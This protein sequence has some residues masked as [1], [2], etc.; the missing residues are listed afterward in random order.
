MVF[1]TLCSLLLR[2][3]IFGHKVGVH[4]RGENAYKTKFGG[5]LSLATYVL[6]T[7]QTYNLFTDFADNSAQTENFVRV[8]QDLLNQGEFNL[9]EQQVEIMITD[10]VKGIYPENIGKWKAIKFS[11]RDWINFESLPI[12]LSKCERLDEEMKSFA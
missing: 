10:S 3:D 5:L 11:I 6:V 12:D 9:R 2:L 8:K 7:I 4:C 1:A